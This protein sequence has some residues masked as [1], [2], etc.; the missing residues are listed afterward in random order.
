MRTSFANL[1]EWRFH[2]A[3]AAKT[4]RDSLAIYEANQHLFTFKDR[5]LLGTDR[6]VWVRIHHWLR[7]ELVIHGVVWHDDLPPN[8]DYKDPAA[9]AM[10]RVF[11]PSMLMPHSKRD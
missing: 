1:R 4:W 9:L 10:R 11:S 3:H 7:R 8:P 6:A 5:Q 2:L